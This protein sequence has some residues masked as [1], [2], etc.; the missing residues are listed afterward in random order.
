VPYNAI[1]TF[2]IKIVLTKTKLLWLELLMNPNRG[3]NNPH[4]I[5]IMQFVTLDILVVNF[6]QVE[7]KVMVSVR[8][9]QWKPQ[10][11]YPKKQ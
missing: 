9:K 7:K 5:P 1:F 2:K 6:H 11:I 4:I 3:I 8:D 10:W